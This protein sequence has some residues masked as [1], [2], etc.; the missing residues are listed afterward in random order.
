MQKPISCLEKL[1]VHN[2]AFNEAPSITAILKL[3]RAAFNSAVKL[4]VIDIAHEV[5]PSWNA[6]PETT[7][8]VVM[9]NSNLYY[10]T[11][12]KADEGRLYKIAVAD[13]ILT[14]SENVLYS[15]R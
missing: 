13:N 2:F 3:R 9:P 5:D 10:T 14:K 8:T 1:K 7:Y 11:I 12:L 15:R 6:I 4:Y